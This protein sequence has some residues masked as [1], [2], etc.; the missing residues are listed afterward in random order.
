MSTDRCDAFRI[1]GIVRCYLNRTAVLP[2]YEMVSRPGF[3]E[4]HDAIAALH[5]VLSG[6]CTRLLPMLFMKRTLLLIVLTRES[7]QSDQRRDQDSRNGW[8]HEFFLSKTTHHSKTREAVPVPR[9]PLFRV[10]DPSSPR[11]TRVAFR[12]FGGRG[13]P[14]GRR[15]V[16]LRQDRGLPDMAHHPERGG[17]RSAPAP[18][19]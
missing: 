9:I 19:A 6:L 7:G 3:G 2:D 15:R 1:L 12:G 14:P 13:F 5:Q 8:F 10:D 4:P 18:G 16:S 11:S 17:E